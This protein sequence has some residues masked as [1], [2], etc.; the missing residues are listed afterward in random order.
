MRCV[1]LREPVRISSTLKHDDQT[2]YW[3][4]AFTPL[5]EDGGRIDRILV[6]SRDITHLKRQEV[7][8]VEANRLLLLAEQVGHFGH[9]HLSLPGRQLTWSD[10]IFRIFDFDPAAITPSFPLAWSR[11]H[12]DDV[13]QVREALD[14]A[15]NHGINYEVSMR[16]IRPDGSIRWVSSRAI[17]EHDESGKVRAV[18]GVFRDLT[19]SKEREQAM[20]QA[21]ET[22]EAMT[23]AKSEFLSTM[24]HELRTPL[25][26]VLG[27]I[28]LLKAQPSVAEAN[29]LLDTL[30]L[31]AESLQSILGDILDFSKIESGRLV[32]EQIDMRVADVV[33]NVVGLFSAVATKRGLVLSWSGD[34]AACEAIVRGDPTRLR[35]VM[36]NLVSNAI[37]F[38]SEGNVALR[39]LPPESGGTLW[40]FEISDTGIGV[41]AA[42][43]AHLFDAFSQADASITRR[44]GG[45]GLGLAISKRIVEA[46]GGQIG[47]ISTMGQGSIFWFEVQLAPVHTLAAAPTE[48]LADP[49]RPTDFALKVL[50]AEDNSVNQMLITTMLRTMGHESVCV[51][52]GRQAIAAMQV[53][54]YDLVLMDMQMPEMDGATATRAIRALDEPLGRL[55]IIGLTA[56]TL[57][58]HV[59]GYMEAGLSGLLGK[60]INLQQ[61]RAVLDKAVAALPET[62]RRPPIISVPAI[63][64]SAASMPATEIVQPGPDVAGGMPSGTSDERRA[65]D[66]RRLDDL[67]GSIGLPMML[68]LLTSFAKDMGKRIAELRMAAQTGDKAALSAIAHAISGA[69]ANLGAIRLAHAASSLGKA[70]R[71]GENYVDWVSDI[72]VAAE[73]TE[74]AVH[75]MAEGE[76]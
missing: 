28:D 3:E 66:R 57:P 49:M 51:G 30:K 44:Y 70:L 52:D 20:R 16:V 33:E 53:G 9:W 41:D 39:V 35:Q 13:P 6:T 26:G 18:F 58:E 72:E 63:P 1:A 5:L 36:S 68:K 37:K 48:R 71:N 34:R 59:A 8:L 10:E 61:L 32:L 17:C 75:Q 4:I 54:D 25:T 45:T 11:Y 40:R 43:Q 46:M 14:G 67:R 74:A 31:S 76:I 64:M 65:F 56:D 23:R 19:E 12:P 55:P 69:S 22:A 7:E 38:T 47:V 21:K 60:P 29:I 73:T 62:R 15:V 50:V 27:M 2:S 24:S 42:T